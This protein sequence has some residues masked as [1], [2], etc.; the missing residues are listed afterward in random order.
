MGSLETITVSVT[1]LALLFGL[2]VMVETFRSAPWSRSDA[3][4]PG[5]SPR[6]RRVMGAGLA[7]MSVGQLISFQLEGDTPLWALSFALIIGGGVC[8]IAAMFRRPSDGNATGP[9]GE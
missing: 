7:L 6:Q 1:V 8:T 9:H 2:A 4:R 5:L 3:A